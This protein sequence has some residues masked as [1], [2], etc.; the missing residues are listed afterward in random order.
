LNEDANMPSRASGFSN[1]GHLIATKYMAFR[2]QDIKLEIPRHRHL[3][4][5]KQD[6]RK[7]MPFLHWFKDKSERN[8]AKTEPGLTEKSASI[9]TNAPEP[10]ASQLRQ[11]TGPGTK[12]IGSGDFAHIPQNPF[13]DSESAIDETEPPPTVPHLSVAIGAFYSKLP[14]H[15]LTS[16]AP[17]LARFVQIAK[18]DVVLDEE[19]EEATLPLSILSLS[20]PEIFIRAVG[21]SD[22]VPVTFSIGRTN[23]GAAVNPTMGKSRTEDTELTEGLRSELD[24]DSWPEPEKP[25]LKTTSGLT[26]APSPP[27]EHAPVADGTVSGEEEIKLRLQT[28]LADFPPQ[29]EPAAIGSLLGTQAEITLPL[30]LIQSQL[31]H[32]R[33]VIPAEIFCKALPSDLKPYFESIDPAAEIPIPLQEIFSQIPLSAIKVREDQE[34]DHPDA[35]IP[36]PFTEHAEEDAKRFTEIPVEANVAADETPES[37]DEP[38]RI[39]VENDSKRLQAIFLTDEPLDLTKAVQNVAGLPGLRS[40]LL[41]TTDGFK[42]AGSFGDSGQEKAIL[43]LLPELFDW[44]GS[45][46]E[47]LQAGTLETI[48][49]Y[50]GL[51]QLSAFVQGK[52]CLT[53]VHDN[54]PFKPGV[55][56]KIRVVLNELAALSAPERTA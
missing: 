22:D 23:A 54:R 52:L 39:T 15:L 49:F 33:V 34:E 16:K 41:S 5:W 27:D 36:T 8:V 26:E 25:T 11:E 37:K 9:P 35:P 50:Y 43:T 47:V 20:C 53:V 56:E 17:D 3:G 19:T 18:D 30:G 48:T 45:K 44:T 14:T 1:Y 40:C 21:G 2:G 42:L 51:H 12:E 38:P 13:A 55:R 28:I 6:T 32:G 46:L 7:D 31:P 4:T 24:D 29:L 10:G